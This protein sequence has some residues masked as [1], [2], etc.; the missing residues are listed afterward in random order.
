[1]PNMANFTVKASNGTTDVV[2]VALTPSAGDT[3]PARWAVTSGASSANLRTSL[4]MKTRPNAKRNARV[5]EVLF[6]M[7]DVRLVNGQDTVV[8]HCLLKAEA[9]IPNQVNISV[10]D[11]A[12]AQFANALKTALIQ[13]SIKVGYAPQ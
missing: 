5:S 9:V 13:D 4:E 7:P 3:T 12:V 6:K 8:G 1:M 2:Y 11:E 10:I